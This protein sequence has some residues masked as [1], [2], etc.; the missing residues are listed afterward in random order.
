MKIIIL[1]SW[2][3]GTASI[4]KYFSNVNPEYISVIDPWC[5]WAN[6]NYHFR[7]YTYNDII[8]EEN[9]IVRSIYETGA[10]IILPVPFETIMSDFDKVVFVLRREWKNETSSSMINYQIKEQ[11][12]FI[13]NATKYNKP[14]FYFEDLFYGDFSELFKELELEMNEELFN[15]FLSPKNKK[16]ERTLI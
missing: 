8:N 14:V 3:T 13:D 7:S 4:M 9:I 2:H 1:Y 11:K 6:S 15:K 16:S 5:P 12:I 10:Q